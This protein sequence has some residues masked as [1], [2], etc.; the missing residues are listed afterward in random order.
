MPRNKE[1]H[2][3]CVSIHDVS[4]HTWPSCQRLLQ[5]I[6]AVAK[7]PVTLLVV[8]AYHRFPDIDTAHYDR[9]LEQRLACGDEL[10]LHGYNHLD[11]GPAPGSLRE[12]FTRHVYTLGE[13]EFAA[14]DAD[15]ARQRLEKGLAWFR[16]RGW[17]VDGF[18]APAWLLGDGAWQALGDFPFKYT[19][20]LKHFYLLPERQ[21]LLSPSL[22]YAARNA[23]S[24]QASRALNSVMSRAIAALPLVRLG[25]HPNDANY[26]S[27][28]AHY[29][30]LIGYLLTTRKAMTKSA[31][32]N[33]W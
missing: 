23:W 9:L 21:A 19:T 4:P 13:G 24:R 33:Q 25:L 5:A 15:D 12:R 17:P 11:D 27:L 18:V 7:I 31:F 16:R 14:I 2:A 22:V 29:Q 20:T 10:A 26:P 30:K 28:V 3:L 8:P 6:G 1:M 32:A